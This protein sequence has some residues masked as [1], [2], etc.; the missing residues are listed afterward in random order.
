VKKIEIVVRLILLGIYCYAGCYFLRWDTKTIFG[1]LAFCA[2]F[3]MKLPNH[4]KDRNGG[5]NNE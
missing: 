2:A 5:N 4:N 1:V 3:N